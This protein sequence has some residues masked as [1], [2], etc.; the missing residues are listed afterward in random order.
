MCLYKA[1]ADSDR[2]I[3]DALGAIADQRGV[4]RAQIALAWLRRNPVVAAPLVGARTAQQIDDAIASLDINLTDDEAR[5]LEMPYTPRHDFQ[6]ISD[7]REM[8]RIKASIP[9]YANL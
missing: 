6:G 9:G 4:S 1:N 8:E 7:E 3:I 5:R 2:Q